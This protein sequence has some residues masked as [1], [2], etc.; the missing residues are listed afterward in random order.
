ETRVC[1]ARIIAASNW[2]LDRAVV[3]RK[4]RQDLFYRLNVLSFYLPPLR[5]RAEDVRMLARGMVAFF[6]KKFK[7]ELFGVHPE[8]LRAL[9]AC[10]WP[11]NIRQLENVI[12]HS[13]LM[14]RGPELLKE[15][16]PQPV[17]GALA[18]PRPGGPTA[19]VAPAGSLAQHRD[20]QERYAIE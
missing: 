11:G 8:A 17:R 3:E 9:A 19:P 20:E 7:K 16:L 14:S 4:F 5:E 15:H 13:V 2:D 12:Q 10:P 1:Q 6:S 18:A